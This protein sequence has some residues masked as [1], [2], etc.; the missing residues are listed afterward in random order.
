MLAAR[1]THASPIPTPSPARAAAV[2]PL[3]VVLYGVEG[4][5]KSTF[6]TQAPSPVFLCPE[7]GVS[8]LD[9]ERFPTPQTWADVFEAIRVLTYEE[10]DYRTLVID[11]IDWLEPLCHEHV[12]ALAGVAH[13]DEIGYGKGYAEVVDQWRQLLGRLES[14]V[15]TRRMNVVLLA[16]ATRKRHE[17]PNGLQDRFQLKIYERAAELVRGW[18]DALLFA[19]RERIT[20]ARKLTPRHPP[21]ARLLHTEGTTSWEARNV[22]EMPSAMPLS[23]DDLST[24]VQAFQPTN[25]AQIRAELVSL[26]PYLQESARAAQVM[27]DWAGDD[28]TKLFQLLE[29]VRSKLTLEAARIES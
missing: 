9:V 8:N 26:I 29:R 24:A 22:F 2:R 4:V 21:E 10:H 19:R 28:P 5:G 17:T 27:R 11:T 23:W 12:C 7:E 25:T 6:A 16:H 14:L 15:R 1:T 3:R 20:L 13:I 18:C